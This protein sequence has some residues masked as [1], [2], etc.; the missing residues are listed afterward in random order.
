[1]EKTQETLIHRNT[2]SRFLSSHFLESAPVT[3]GLG[4][5]QIWFMNNIEQEVLRQI[6]LHEFGFIGFSN[7]PASFQVKAEY[8]C[9]ELAGGISDILKY[10]INAQCLF[11]QAQEENE[12]VEYAQKSQVIRELA[13]EGE[14]LLKGELDDLAWLIYKVTCKH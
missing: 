6:V 10:F 1:M 12:R 3:E 9:L 11:L 13:E 5:F 7:I 2:F 8:M 14:F 4:V